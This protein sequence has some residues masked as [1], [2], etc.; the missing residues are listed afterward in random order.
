[1]IIFYVHENVN[2]PYSDIYFLLFFSLS[3]PH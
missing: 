1:M 3:R 2:C